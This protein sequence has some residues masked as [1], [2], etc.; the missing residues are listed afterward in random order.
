MSHFSVKK[1]TEIS[2]NSSSFQ[3]EQ[4]SRTQ[5]RT[6]APLE[7]GAGVRH[8]WASRS[9]SYAAVVAPAAA[10]SCGVR[11]RET[12]KE[13]STGRCQVE[14][15]TQGSALLLFTWAVHRA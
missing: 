6:G 1:K 5:P 7:P 8:Q 11:F 12:V 13:Q 4:Q 9:P 2:K 10:P 15:E 14:M 3:R